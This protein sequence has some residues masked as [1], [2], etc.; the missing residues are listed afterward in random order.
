[1]AEMKHTSIH[2]IHSACLQSLSKGCLSLDAQALAHVLRQLIVYSSVVKR[3]WQ[4][5][6]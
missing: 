3:R 4:L 2:A 6:P 1:M 5:F